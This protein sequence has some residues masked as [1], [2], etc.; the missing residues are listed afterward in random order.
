MSFLCFSFLSWIALRRSSLLCSM[1][2]LISICLV[3]WMVMSLS[4]NNSS[5]YQLALFIEY[6][7]HL[8][9]LV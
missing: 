8:W 1:K 2:Y 6:P 9:D 5:F 7:T 4:M 3:N